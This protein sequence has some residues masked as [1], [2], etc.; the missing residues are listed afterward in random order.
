MHKGKKGV[1]AASAIGAAAVI[2]G[3]IYFLA[4]GV[5]PPPQVNGDNDNTTIASPN[6]EPPKMLLVL[7]EGPEDSSSAV[8]QYESNNTG[9]IQLAS[10]AH[11]R[12]DSAEYRTAEGMRVTA[13][14]VDTGAIELLRKSYNINNEFF[15][16]L[17]QGH[18][19]LQ[20]QASWFEKGTFGYTFDIRVV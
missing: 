16:N 3:V 1:I 5:M 13:R 18:Y 12:F 6:G 11:V 10:G 9:A 2:A 14:N 20:V 4:P 17:E 8:A 15:I 7:L 19:E